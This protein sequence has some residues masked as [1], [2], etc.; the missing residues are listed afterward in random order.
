[1][2]STRILMH[3][4]VE[5]TITFNETPSTGAFWGLGDL[6]DGVVI[7]GE[8]FTPWSRPEVMGT[9][10]M[11]H[12]RVR[13]DSPGLHEIFATKKRPWQHDQEPLDVWKVTLEIVDG[14]EHGDDLEGA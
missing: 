2:K 3:V 6:P 7:V 8:D 9:E 12:F 13:A 14:L 10:G 4:G 11:H 1:M 5:A